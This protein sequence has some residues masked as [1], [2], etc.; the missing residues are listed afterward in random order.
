MYGHKGRGVELAGGQAGGRASAGR[1]ALGHQAGHL[2]ARQRHA[3]RAGAHADGGALPAAPPAGP[4]APPARPSP[5]PAAPLQPAQPG[6][7]PARLRR[8]PLAAECQAK[9][10]TFQIST[11]IIF[12]LNLYGK[13]N[14]NGSK[15]YWWF[16]N[17]RSQLLFVVFKMFRQIGFLGFQ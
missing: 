16:S 4:D 13:N 7:Q 11:L 3:E 9:C 1:E 10:G 12:C 14:V 2:L 6:R 8:R 15:K 5:A 17:R